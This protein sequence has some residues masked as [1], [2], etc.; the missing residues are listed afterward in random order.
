[1]SSFSFI[2]I[3]FLVSLVLTFCS[4]KIVLCRFDCASNCLHIIEQHTLSDGSIQVKV[5][6]STCKG[7]AISWLACMNAGCSVVSCDGIPVSGTDKCDGVVQGTYLFAPETGALALFQM[8]DGVL[9]GNV[10]CTSGG[11][12]NCSGGSGGGCNVDASGNTV[13]L[14]VCNEP[15]PFLPGDFGSTPGCTS[16]SDCSA[17][18]LCTV[19][20]CGSD[21]NCYQ[22]LAPTTTVCRP[23]AGV[24]DVA[25]NCDG[26]NAACPE[27]LFLDSTNVCRPAL[28]F[29]ATDPSTCDIPEY[30][31]GSDANCPAD[32]IK[33]S[34]PT[35]RD[36][37]YGTDGTTCDLAE[38][39]DG[40]NSAC[41]A[42]SF[43][44][45][46]TLCRDVADLCDVPEYCTADSGNA[47]PADL[48]Q[49]ATYSCRPA[50]TAV[51]GTT[52]DIAEYCDGT[53]VSCPAVDAVMAAGTTC[54]P[55]ANPCDV[56]D[57]CDGTSN[58]CP[59]D[60]RN[61]DGYVYKCGLTCFLCAVQESQLTLSS[62]SS[63]QAWS[64][65]GCTIG[66]CDNFVVLQWPQ[67][68]TQCINALCPNNKALSNSEIYSCNKNNGNWVCDYKLDGTA[69]ANGVCPTWV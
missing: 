5:D 32:Q 44:T 63:T 19:A 21:G 29:S 26:A 10:E 27:D 24:C 12:S 25:E 40:V 60:L 15:I 55:N 46:G 4:A 3:L 45:P 36:I 2:K 61:D 69:V 23:S 56:V 64:L 39:C 13:T 31:T 51:D 59:S 14:H 7:S 65:G 1:M 58:S 49:P 54:R 62:G 35:C 52:C 9:A 38:T 34:G 47:C 33:E 20:H 17:S 16:D 22:T 43:K 37:V 67:C 18:N 48:V 30:W 57:N 42:D 41:P 11:S 53:T 66:G 68:A 28:P 50:V 8:H 6:A